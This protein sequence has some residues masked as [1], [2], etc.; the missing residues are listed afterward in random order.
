MTTGIEVTV[1][2]R[3]CGC[4]YV[5]TRADYA[6]GVWRLCPGCRDTDQDSAIDPNPKP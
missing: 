5:P 1:T 3:R 6:Q 2:C 4:E